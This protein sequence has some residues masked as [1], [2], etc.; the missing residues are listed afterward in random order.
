MTETVQRIRA[1]KLEER[2]NAIARLI[3]ESKRKGGI[4][5]RIY[6][7]MV[8]DFEMAPLTTNR[9]QLSFCGI[10]MPPA[11]EVSE[12]QMTDILK[13]VAEGLA[14]F[15][16]YILHAECFD[17]PSLYE[18]IFKVLDEEVREVPPDPGVREYIDLNYNRPPT[19][20]N[21]VRDWIPV[22]PPHPE[23]PCPE[24]K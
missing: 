10:H 8:Y 21:H 22:A 18:K 2:T 4:T 9:A 3:E 24:S 5:D 16:I 13:K 1:Q 17:T 7:T 23:N 20:E 6:W 15:S 19:D 14:D 12:D 11:T